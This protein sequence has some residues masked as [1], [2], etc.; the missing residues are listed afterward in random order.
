MEWF[1]IVDGN[2]NVTV[3]MENSM[4]VPWNMKVELLYHLVISLLGIYWK[5][6]KSGSLI[7]IS[8]HV[9]AAL[10]ILVKMC[11]Q[12]KCPSTLEQISKL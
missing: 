9:I 10:I 6:M 8:F 3:A 5:K 12:P 7:D 11:K 2:V 1:Y 4:V